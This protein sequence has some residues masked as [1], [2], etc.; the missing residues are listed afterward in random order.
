MNVSR[1]NHLVIRVR[2]ALAASLAV[3]A[4]LFQ[5]PGSCPASDDVRQFVP[6]QAGYPAGSVDEVRTLSPIPGVYRLSGEDH[7]GAYTGT[8]ELRLEAGVH[9]FIR[10]VD[11]TDLA[12]KGYGISLLQEGEARVNADGSIQLSY[13]LDRLDV[14]EGADQRAVDADGHQ[15]PTRVTET[16]TPLPTA[17]GGYRGT[18]RLVHDGRVRTFDETWMRT[19][20]VGATTIWQNQRVE[21]VA[22]DASTPEILGMAQPG[23]GR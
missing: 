13:E 7:L 10:L 17:A 21:L 3:P 6:A 8:G 9:R 12:Y 22:A 4:L 18:Y 16:L 5:L 23:L 15:A 11:Y 2:R 19:G 14:P 20:R 1:T